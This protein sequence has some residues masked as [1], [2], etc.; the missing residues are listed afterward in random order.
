MHDLILAIQKKD[1]IP[2]S[3]LK[4]LL[5]RDEINDVFILTKTMEICYYGENVLQLYVFN[6]KVRHKLRKKELIFDEIECDDGLL[7]CKTDIANLPYLLS[8][9][10]VKKR[11]K[12]NSVW[13]KKME[14]W[15][16]HKI[17]PHIIESN[18]KKPIPE[19]LQKYIFKKKDVEFT[20]KKVKN[21]CILQM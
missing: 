21:N 15:L 17:I 9:N 14:K 18:E 3:K 13:I 10:S 20:N 4:P 6:H 5:W 8:I 16:G 11:F 2:I 1:I 7:W 19:H 12:K